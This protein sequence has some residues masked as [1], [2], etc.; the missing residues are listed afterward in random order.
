MHDLLI[1]LALLIAR[2]SAPPCGG[3]ASSHPEALYSW[4]QCVPVTLTA[5]GVTGLPP[6]TFS[7]RFSNG[8]QRTGNPHT[9]DT[10]LFDPGLHSFQL[11][12]TNAYGSTTRPAEFF[13]IEELH[14]LQPP[15]YEHLGNGLVRF[16]AN[17]EGA[18]EYRWT[19][20]D[21][22]VSPW[23]PGCDGYR[24]EH[25]YAD[26][27]TYTA[28]LQARNCKDPVLVSP[29]FGVEVSAEPP[30]AILEFAADCPFGFCLFDTGEPIA[31]TTQVQGDPI[32]YA[33]DWDGDGLTDQ[34]TSQAVATHAYAVAGTYRPRLTISRGMTAVSF[35][36]VD[37]LIVLPGGGG[38]G[39]I[40][41]DGF[42][43]GDTSAWSGGVGERGPSTEDSR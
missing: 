3:A 27:G 13:F 28:Q 38:T 24:A 31:F 18:V 14:F 23:L 16:S 4:P 32:T 29:P 26:P 21:G 2:L 9:F 19:F 25:T 6:L 43:S 39:A 36:H 10:A 12:V 17:V 37:F 11:T 40:F 41:A 15:G 8:L 35:L 7:W 1:Y 22:T 20:G 42:E 34:I 33:Y 5:E 30:L